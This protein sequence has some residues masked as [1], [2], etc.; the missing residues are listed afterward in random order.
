MTPRPQ[1]R[2]LCLAIG[3]LM[4]AVLCTAQDHAGDH[5]AHQMPAARGWVWHGEAQIMFGFNA[6][7]RQFR[8]FHVWE[9]QN[10]FMADGQ[11][12]L[13]LLLC[14]RLL[15]QARQ[16]NPHV[17][18]AAGQVPAVVGHGGEVGSQLL[19][20]VASH[21]ERGDPV[22]LPPKPVFDHAELSGGVG[23]A[24]RPKPED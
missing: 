15:P 13:V 12:P 18:V 11:R 9:S 19:V 21:S 2:T 14:L 7:E 17:G 24:A 20:A 5:A 3:V 16:Q 10:W 1:G 22:L 4:R 6:Q 23:G 8:D